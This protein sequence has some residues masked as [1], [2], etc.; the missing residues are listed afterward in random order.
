MNTISRLRFALLLGVLTPAVALLALTGDY[1]G[2]SPA[3]AAPPNDNFANAAPVT[4]PGVSGIVAIGSTVGASD[5]VSEPHAC[6]AA[7]TVWYNWMSPAGTGTVVFDTYGSSFDTVLSIY[8]GSTLNALDS[9]GCNDDFGGTFAPSA[10]A[11]TYAATTTYRIQVGGFLGASGNTVLN[12]SLGAEIVVNNTADNNASDAAITLREAML[13]ARGGTGA[14]GLGRAL[15][16]S[17]PGFTLNSAAAGAAASDLIHF[18]DTAFPIGIGGFI[19]TGSSLPDLNGT[20]DVVSGI[21]AGPVV[22]GT[23]KGTNPCFTLS[24]NSNVVEG[25]QGIVTCAAAVSVTGAGNRVGGSI[26]P[27]QGNTIDNNSQ[28]VLISGAAATANLVVGNRIGTDSLAKNTTGI[29]INSGA[30]DNTIGG[31]AA[32]Q[33]NVVNLATSSGIE[34]NSVGSTGNAIYG[35]YI[36]TDGAF[37]LGNSSNGVVIK[38]GAQANT[39]GGAAVG[40]GNLIS[41]NVSYGVSIEDATST[42]NV[43]RGNVLGLN[44]AGTLKLPNSVGIAIFSSSNTIGGASPGEGNVSSGN[45]QGINISLGNNNLVYGNKIGTNAAGTAAMANTTYGV[46]LADRNNIIGGTAAGQGNTIAY[47]QIGVTTTN[48]NALGN[49]IRGNSIYGNTTAGI[50]NT[51]GGNLELPPPSVTSVSGTNVNGIACNSCT[52]D[53]YND[54]GAQGRL[55]MGTTTANSAGLWTLGSGSHP[56]PNI[57]TL[58]VDANNNTSEFSE[59]FAAPIDS[60]GDGI[61]NA[62]DECASSAEDADGFQDGDGCPDPDNDGDGVCDAGQTA[63]TCAGSDSGKLCFD[64]AGTLSCATQD[65]RSL[66]EDYDAFK[67]TDGC[68]EPDN[69][70][71]GFPDVTDQC[72]G[73]GSQAGADGMLGSPQDLNHNGIRDNPPEG[74]FTLDDVVLVFEDYDLVLDGDGCHDSPGEDFDG[75]GYADEV[76]A[77]DIG[78]NAGYPCGI[79]GWPS[80]LFEPAVPTPAS[81]LNTLTIQDILSYVAPVRH[82]GTSPPNSLYD[83]R[84]DLL[85]G[86]GTLGDYINI[87]DLIET[88]AQTPTGYPPMLNGSVPSGRP[89]RFPRRAPRRLSKTVIGAE[90]ESVRP[91]VACLFTREPLT[92]PPGCAPMDCNGADDTSHDQRRRHDHSR[93]AHRRGPDARPHAVLPA[94]QLPDGVAERFRPRLVRRAVTRTVRPALRLPGRR[95]VRPRRVRLL[96]GDSDR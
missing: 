96:A 12:M 5:E 56:L 31:A 65:C 86:P 91:I 39:V 57:T 48:N 59:P 52:V 66:A 69:D 37:G 89:A 54:L 60:D 78:T 61:S 85:P 82:F 1:I 63:L 79:N 75:D 24:G 8:T 33:R 17:E 47:N 84:W 9:A 93:L 3:L 76:E 50:D 83:K 35:N 68:P 19:A 21:G 30:H 15:G 43:V 40:Q 90:R 16:G 53:V 77:L 11:L 2:H 10:V 14:G 23:G 13:L 27:G 28:G 94:Q 71:D 95:A 25:M 38:N 22:L 32:G 26:L 46:V 41:A 62:N 70:N 67:D 87:Q 73:T 74:V 7:N 44:A 92:P 55:Y 64:P 58:A 72:P 81:P 49:A 80:N 29:L 34:I 4:T 20:G 45:G 18:S 51:G 88:I 36:G 42:Q 6:G